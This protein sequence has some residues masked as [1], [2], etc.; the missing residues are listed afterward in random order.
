ML[1]I[2]VD[3]IYTNV[4]LKY[5]YVDLQLTFRGPKTTEYFNANVGFKG[6]VGFY[7][8]LQHVF[9]VSRNFVRNVD[10]KLH[11]GP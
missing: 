3:L 9:V 6:G 11:R 5:I 7:N 4:E 10:F 2:F 8:L 1:A